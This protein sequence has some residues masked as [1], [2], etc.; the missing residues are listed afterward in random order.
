MSTD[1][2]ATEVALLGTYHMDNPGLDVVNV[3]A[4]DV[5]EP[6]R[7]R[8][9]EAL[10][11]RL[12][13][14][15]P[16]AVAVERPH[17]RQDDLDALYGE[18]RFGDRRYDE[19]SEID[20]PHPM[21]DDP[22]AE[23]RSEVVQVGFRTADRMDHA[24]VHA[25][26]HPM[27]LVDADEPLDFEA[28]TQRAIDDLDVSLPEPEGMQRRS[29]EHLAESTVLEHLRWRN[30]EPQLRENHDLMFAGAFAGVDEH[31]LGSKL[32]SGW[33]ERNLRIV[34]NLFELAD[35]E[36]DRILLVI[37]AGH[38]RVLEHLLEEAPMLEPFGVL[39]VLSE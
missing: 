35:A 15:G 10:A 1:P 24:G 33:Y 37:G 11:D 2:N 19:E 38:V 8:E 21:R 36:T 12:E 3:D 18:Y 31:Y 9:L 17:E 32:L 7:Q 34:E 39:P 16:D 29:D 20:P 22:H 27:P 23:C 14:W 13:A 30:R 26:D 28:A 6:E 4:D 25:V 5:L